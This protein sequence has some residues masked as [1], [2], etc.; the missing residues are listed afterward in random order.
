MNS[1]K[2]GSLLRL[3]V[4]YNKEKQDALKKKKKTMQVYISE[5]EKGTLLN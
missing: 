4:H 3:C 5:I 2:T 1:E